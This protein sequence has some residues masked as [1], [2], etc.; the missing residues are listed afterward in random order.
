[1]RSSTILQVF[2]ENLYDMGSED[3]SIYIE[4]AAAQL[5]SERSTFSC[6]L[7][8]TLVVRYERTSRARQSLHERPDAFGRLFQQSSIPMSVDL[9]RLAMRFVRRG[10]A[11]CA[12]PLRGHKLPTA[13]HTQSTRL[14]YA[15]VGSQ[16]CF[17]S[18]NSPRS[19]CCRGHRPA[20]GTAV[21]ITQASR[22]AVSAMSPS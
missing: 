10:Q 6:L 16:F 12:L 1:M 3:Q 19:R 11:L 13:G 17:F 8:L 14:P 15:I 7:L 21:P 2:A 22:A 5:F 9:P 20:A 4:C 18:I